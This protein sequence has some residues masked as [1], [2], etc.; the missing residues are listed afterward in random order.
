M[1]LGRHEAELGWAERRWTVVLRP[2]FQSASNEMI[3][4]NSRKR[5]S[6]RR[7]VTLHDRHSGPSRTRS[8]WDIGILKLHHLVDDKMHARSTG[9]YSCHAAPLGSKAQFGGSASGRWRSGRLGYGASNT[10]R[11]S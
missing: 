1:N 11:S 10:L 2:V 8:P 3:E 7:Q 4:P 6:P 9:P 5:T